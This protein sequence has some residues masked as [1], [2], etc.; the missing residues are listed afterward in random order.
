MIQGAPYSYNQV[1]DSLPDGTTLKM[2]K[3][4]GG[5]A[6]LGEAEDKLEANLK[7]FYLGQFPVTNIQYA[8]FLNAYGS[9][10]V[11]KG[12]HVG[13]LMVEEYQWGVQ[14]MEDSWQPSKGFEEHPVVYVTWYGAVAYCD[15]LSEKTGKTYRLPSESEWEYA[16][17]GGQ[18]SLGFRYAG[19]HK[20]KEVGWYR[21]N[22]HR[23]TKPV[24]LK[25]PNELGLYDMSGNVWEWCAD[26]WHANFKEARKDGTTWV[27]D[28]KTLRV[29][30]GGS[31][32]SVGYVC[33]VSFRYWDGA[34]DW[35]DITGFRVARY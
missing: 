8:A 1:S 25:I 14:K 22:S 29:V 18:E 31:W 4:K 3:I 23:V 15:W 17:K 28:D 6:Q 20:L 34:G 11:I 16:A 10:K 5:S 35:G 26:H 12:K 9:D 21:I 27:T 13:K 30:R 7:D 2:I 32:V 33:R 19:S 24:G